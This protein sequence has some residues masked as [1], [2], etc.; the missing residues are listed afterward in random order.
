MNCEFCTVE[1]SHGL[2][3]SNMFGLFLEVKGRK[4]V[5]QESH[6]SHIEEITLHKGKG[7][8]VL[9]SYFLSLRKTDFI[10]FFLLQ[11]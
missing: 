1:S 5:S 9:Q 7:D 11:C 4:N 8:R 2:V 3:C 6:F 10:L